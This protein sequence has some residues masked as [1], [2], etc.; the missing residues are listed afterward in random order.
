MEETYNIKDLWIC[1]K[2]GRF[3]YYKFYEHASKMTT[4]NYCRGK[5]VKYRTWLN[6]IKG[7]TI[8]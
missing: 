7:A 6:Y 5:I 3:S 8:R 1:V 2:C 4:D